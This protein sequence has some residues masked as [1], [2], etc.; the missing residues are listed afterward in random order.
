[1]LRTFVDKSYHLLRKGLILILR[2]YQYLISPQLGPRCR[3]FPSCS[4]YAVE[5]LTHYNIFKGF[6]LI[7]MRII[8]CHPFHPGGYDP[9]IILD[10]QA[11]NC[12]QINKP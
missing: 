6:S 5:A 11:V 10:N 8:R 2:G 4:H 12:E 7:F 1:M 3:F 9:L